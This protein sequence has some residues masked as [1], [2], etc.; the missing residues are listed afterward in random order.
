M[1]D[2]QY[3]VD[4]GV[5]TLSVR[6]ESTT[7]IVTRRTGSTARVLLGEWGGRFLSDH[8][9]EKERGRG[10]NLKS[11]HEGK[12]D[13]W[14]CAGVLPGIGGKGPLEK[15]S[16]RVGLCADVVDRKAQGNK[17]IGWEGFDFT[18]KKKE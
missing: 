7:K 12:T 1:E 4:L 16:S 8:E 9:R 3:P 10:T 2:L 14:D 6:S 18:R 15:F 17:H 13:G 11:S 5:E